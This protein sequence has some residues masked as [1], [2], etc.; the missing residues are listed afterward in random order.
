[1]V[2]FLSARYEAFELRHGRTVAAKRS[3]FPVR[4]S[5][6]MRWKAMALVVMPW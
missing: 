2:S 4:V 6:Q 3:S 5:V 1:M